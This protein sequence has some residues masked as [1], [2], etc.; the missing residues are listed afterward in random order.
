[1]NSAG[2]L[3]PITNLRGKVSLALEKA[4]DGD[5]AGFYVR[6]EKRTATL[7]IFPRIDRDVIDVRTDK[8]NKRRQET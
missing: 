8:R 4:I 7:E 6:I 1:M 5:I 2:E 3:I